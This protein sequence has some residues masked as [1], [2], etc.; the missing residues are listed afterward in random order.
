MTTVPYVDLAQQHQHIKNE[1]LHAV[2]LVLSRGDFILGEEVGLF[3]KNIASYCGTKFA[4][5]VN[6]GTDGLFLALK[7]YNIGCGD[8][9]IV[10]PNSFLATASAV[11]AAGAV[12]VYV[13]VTRDLNINP[14]LIEE[15]ITE[16]TKAIIPVHL[17]G[18]PADMDPILQIAKKY[19]LKVIEDA[20]Q[21]MGAEYKGRKVGS[22]GDIGCFSLHPLKTLNACGDAGI[23]TFDDEEV[24]LTL[25]QLRNIGLK[26]RNQSEIWGYNSRLDTMQAAILNVKLRYLDQ[27]NEA[28][29]AS[30]KFYTERLGDM[31]LTPK[32]KPYEKHVY[33]TYMIQTP[34]REKLKNFLEKQC[35]GTKIHY[36]TPIHMQ[37]AAKKFG[38]YPLGSFPLT[39]QLANEV[40]SLPIHQDL[41]YEQIEYVVDNIENF[42][43]ETESDNA[44]SL[45]SEGLA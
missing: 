15:C 13:D 11:V 17:S 28:R 16:K 23:M 26:N 43:K 34:Q 27:W 38:N 36:P 44:F 9:V 24:Y 41:T 3:E 39:E 29:Q 5:G 33:L 14:E 42:F 1:I 12:P 8:E 35:I 10:P 7:A 40:L 6:S 31:V 37:E 22:L 25:K 19:N 32:P 21:A 4:L 18:C 45:S 2:D 30:A 20:A